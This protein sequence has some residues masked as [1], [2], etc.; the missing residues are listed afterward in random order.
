MEFSATAF[1]KYP[2]LERFGHNEVFGIEDGLCAV[3]PKLDGT[4]GSVWYEN[5]RLWAGSRNRV[6]SREEDNHGFLAWFLD[7]DAAG[8][9]RTIVQ[10]NPHVRFYGEWLVPHSLRTYREDAWRRFWIFDVMVK[11][12]GKFLPWYGGVEGFKSLD[13]VHPLAF[14]HRPSENDL[15]RELERNTFL[16]ADG[17]GLGEGIVIKRYDYVNPWGRTTWAKIVRNEF[18]EKNLGA[19]GAPVRQGERQVEAEI[20]D[21]FVTPAFVAKERA[22]I[23]AEV[24]EAANVPEWDESVGGL[25][26]ELRA[27]VIPRLLQT[28]FYELIREEAWAFVKKHRNPTIDF[29][30]LQRLTV[31]RTKQLASDLF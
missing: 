27:K 17:M 10:A 19:F 25:S 4:N 29:G 11:E 22:K 15:R 16:I 1:V 13:L 18:K 12:S 21:H 9:L 23:E 5:G 7:S 3:Y 26:R 20:V 2:H 28:V 24:C 14:V 30:K 31:E 6:L 8:E